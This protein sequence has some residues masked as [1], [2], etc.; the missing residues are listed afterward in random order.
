MAEV[1]K[2]KSLPNGFERVLQASEAGNSYAMWK[3]GTYFSE[4][5]WCEQDFV[6]ALRWY[7]RSAEA[8]HDLGRRSAAEMLTQGLGC[9]SP[10]TDEAFKYFLQGAKAGDST[11][12]Y[13]AGR[14][15]LYGIGTDVNI[16]DATKYLQLAEQNYHKDAEALLAYLNAMGSV[17]CGSRL[18]ALSR[19]IEESRLGN[20]L[21]SYAIGVWWS[22]G[23]LGR[24]D[25][26]KA[27]SAFGCAHERGDANATYRLA[28][29]YWRGVGVQQSD[30]EAF[31]LLEISASKGHRDGN[32]L[33]GA[34]Y[35]YGHFGQKMDPKMA[36]RYL[37]KAVAEDH[38][39]AMCDLASMIQSVCAT[40][41][42]IKQSA[43]L[44]A[45]AL[46][47]GYT[48]AE[49]GLRQMWKEHRDLFPSE[50]VRRWIFDSA[51]CGNTHS[52]MD[53]A[54]EY[55]YGEVQDETQGLFW[56]QSAVDDNH[57]RAQ[58][59]LGY[60]LIRLKK[61]TSDEAISYLKSASSLG[62]TDSAYYLAEI[63]YG[64]GP[65]QDKA[66]CAK[67]LR[68]SAEGGNVHAQLF[69]A[70]L[71]DHG[72]GVP[73]NKEAAGYWRH[74]AESKE[75]DEGAIVIPLNREKVDE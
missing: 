29:F 73:Q 7:R 30:A 59:G 24:I 75:Q 48:D 62:C 71:L 33:M 3:L 47:L 31:S 46:S 18:E 52:M 57:I 61:K 9:P 66:K 16:D 22:S 42:N 64:K 58:Y 36:R 23:H 15:L 53:L 56:L 27:L 34:T 12:Q 38:P 49:D 41:E 5:R 39:Q 43:D 40:P 67:Y 51:S 65:R 63:Y 54:Y 6:E 19:L 60:E 14:S 17:P 8:G 13:F 25:Y 21:A 2:I 11:C 20:S 70:H 10:N 45:K 1:T 74:I 28:L 50:R 72:D 69:L 37:E 68:L 32:A 26:Q 55:L 4:G 35:L 44:Y